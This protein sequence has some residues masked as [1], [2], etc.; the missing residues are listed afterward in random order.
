MKREEFIA[1][2]RH[3]AWCCYQIAAEQPYNLE[4]T[5][6]QL[7]SML[8]GV[9]FMLEHPDST[10]EENHNNWM[11]C[12]IEQGWIYGKEKDLEKKTHFDLVPFDEL[13]KIEKDKDVMDCLMTREFNKL[14]EIIESHKVHLKLIPDSDGYID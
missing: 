7:D 1:R 10:P 6:D 14:W 4:P 5:K 3:L 12:K 2:A 13:L 9:K 8:N 11:K